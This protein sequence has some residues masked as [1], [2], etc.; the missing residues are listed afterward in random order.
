MGPG[1]F[2]HRLGIIGMLSGIGFLWCRLLRGRFS[3]LRQLGQTSLLIYW[4][5]IELC[6]GS[7]VFALRGRFHVA[8]ATLLVLVLT[9]LMLGLSL[10][11]TH[12]GRATVEWLRRRFRKPGL[13]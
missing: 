10:L 11:K 5:H 2:F 9:V 1:I 3:V 6:Y 12:H 4:V 13:A 7:F 8:G